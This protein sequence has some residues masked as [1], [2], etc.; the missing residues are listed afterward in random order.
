[1]ANKLLYK[2]EAR[3][4]I[5]QGVD[6][7]VD[8]I[9]VTLGPKGQNGVVYKEYGNPIVTN[10]GISL[11]KEIEVEDE[12][13]NIGARL[14]KE[15]ASKT[16]DATGDGTTTA[17]IL[18]QSMASEGLKHI[19]AGYNPILLREALKSASKQVIETL[20]KHS[21]N[22]D[23]IQDITNVAT[24][25]AQDEK[26]G[27]AI[28]KI[29]DKIG[30]NAVITVEPAHK[31]GLFTDIVEGMQ[32]NQGYLSPYMVTDKES[33]KA[34]LEAPAILLTDKTISTLND[35]MNIA[36]QVVH[37]LENKNILIVAEDVK[38]D[39]LAM[40][41]TNHIKGTFNCAAVKAPSFASNKKE[42]LEDIAVLTD[43]KII[44]SDLGNSL[45]DINADMFGTAEK[46]VVSQD[47]T[48]IV[49]N[50]KDS[51][52]VKKRIKQLEK[53]I[54]QA[55]S[56]YKKEKIKERLAKLTSGVAVI[57]IGAA[58][59]VERKEKIDKVEDAVNATR[60]GIEEGI[61]P[62]GG[63][64]LFRIGKMLASYE[65]QD[66]NRMAANQIISQALQAPA[67]Q[68]IRNAG[69]DS[70]EVLAQLKD[71]FAYGY[72]AL[73][74]QYGD[75]TDQGIIDPTKVVK[76][77]FQNAISVV[78]SLLTVETAI[79]NTV[80]ETPQEQQNAV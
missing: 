11:L 48:T 80:E 10:D 75:L 27:Q 57:S 45:Q 54:E 70:S 43:A 28:A 62:G 73:T 52:D 4:N 60:A 74:G 22:I 14:V 25:S 42:L 39:A 19:T 44:S 38:G 79:V 12:F 15:A 26:V 21:V 51:S 71:K 59:E 64:P 29:F 55:E 37:E 78:C 68:I 36:N 61:L 67:R 58:T 33:R 13:Q 5:K 53:D 18:V 35:A 66:K 9:K 40:F 31:L 69:Q 23:N 30:Q 47:T 24:I 50:Q 65:T 32:F 49:S 6:K 46:V 76:S 3:K 20:D 1:M 72:N 34:T 41:M 63:I 2:E 17:S 16:N 7:L 77:A 56:D 8:A